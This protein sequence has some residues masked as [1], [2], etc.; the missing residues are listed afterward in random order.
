MPQKFLGKV[1]R[2][3][4]WMNRIILPFIP[5]KIHPNHIT[6]LRLF[7]IPFVIW[8][9]VVGDYTK[10]F[11]IFI[12]AAFTDAVDGSMARIRNQVTEVGKVL[13]PIADKLLITSVLVILILKGLNFYLALSIIFI[14]V[15]FII[16]G[17]WRK[18][19][20]KKVEANVWGKVKMN[21]QVLGISLLF[22]GFILKSSMINS[23]S[24]FALSLAI[25]FAIMSLLSAGI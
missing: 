13:D 20:N 19:R 23:F 1:Y 5:K 18:A 15:V 3:D 4:I 14:E 24:I 7:L 16:G 9:L 25:I 12:M 8:F 6:I 22:F 17:L 21:L 2:H 11:I 10:G